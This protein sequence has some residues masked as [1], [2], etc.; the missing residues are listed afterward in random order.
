MFSFE[1]VIIIKFT[2]WFII[3]IQFFIL[4][5]VSFYTMFHFIAKQYGM[6]T[7]EE[8]AKIVFHALFYEMLK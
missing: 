8:K 6:E 7:M 4:Y 3:P 5:N 1:F 2:H